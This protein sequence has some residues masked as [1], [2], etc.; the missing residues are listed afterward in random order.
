MANIRA[1][2]LAALLGLCAG[3]ALADICVRNGSDTRML[4]V[5]ET[6][7]ARE[8][9]W[10]EP[11]EELCAQGAEH[12]RVSV[13]EAEDSLEG[14]TWLVPAGRTEILLNYTAF[15]NCLWQSHLD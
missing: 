3:P 8:V 6:G 13:F 7:A 12:G 14:C 5:A 10:L 1:A 11:G 9:R 2:A 15:D 4:F